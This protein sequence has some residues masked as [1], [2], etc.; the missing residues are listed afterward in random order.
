[1][2]ALLAD[3]KT[4][5][6]IGSIEHIFAELASIKRLGLL[7]ER[8]FE[9]LFYRSTAEWQSLLVGFARDKSETFTDTELA[10][11]FATLLGNTKGPHN[12]FLLPQ[13]K[14]SPKS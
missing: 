8:L 12:R 3:R 4:E 7:D 5:E 14:D 10:E 6:S 1:M 13:P 9:A 11:T 2:A